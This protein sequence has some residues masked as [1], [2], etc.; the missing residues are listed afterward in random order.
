MSSQVVDT[1][2]AS[3]LLGL[4]NGTLRK[5][6]LYGNGPRFVKLGRAVRYRVS[7]LDA[8]LD[9]RVLCSTSEKVAG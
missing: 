6:R 5:M 2:E 1:N 8:Y 9:A 3:R 4:S 7:E